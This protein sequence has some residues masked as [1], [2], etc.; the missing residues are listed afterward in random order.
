MNI[1]STST[2]LHDG[3]ILRSDYCCKV[4]RKITDIP[5][6]MCSVAMNT[7]TWRSGDKYPVCESARYDK[8]ISFVLEQ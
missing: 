1:M 3:Q 4:E 6:G 7:N 8:E 2:K 5:H